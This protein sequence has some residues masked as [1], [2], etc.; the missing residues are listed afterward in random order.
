MGK[1]K[2][3]DFAIYNDHDYDDY[4]LVEITGYKTWKSHNNIETVEF[5]Y[6]T[7]NVF[8][9]VGMEDYTEERFLEFIGNEKTVFIEYLINLLSDSDK[10][11]DL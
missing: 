6:L 3:G 2:P 5:K 8:A 9:Y 10:L 1:F 11:D 4:Y 7:D